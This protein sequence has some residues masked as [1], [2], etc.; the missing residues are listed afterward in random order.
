MLSEGVG[1]KRVGWYHGWTIVSVLV[2]V[3]GASMGRMLPK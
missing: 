2:V 1:T 3:R